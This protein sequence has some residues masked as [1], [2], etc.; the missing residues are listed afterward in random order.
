MKKFLEKK[1]AQVKPLFEEGGK[2]EKL[3]P[4]WEAHETIFFQP[5]EVTKAKGAHIRDANDMKRLMV[6]LRNIK[7]NLDDKDSEIITI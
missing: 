3:F 5:N 4:V 1:I 7:I 6:K 2:F